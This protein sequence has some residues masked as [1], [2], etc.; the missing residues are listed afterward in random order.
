MV[1]SCFALIVGGGP[2]GLSLAIDLGRRNVPSILITE[3]FE[4]SPH[5]KC[6]YSN[7]RTVE[8]FRRL[9]IADLIRAAGVHGDFP[10]EVAFRTRFCGHEIARLSLDFLK[11][12]VWPGPEYPIQI[13][14]IA[15]EPALK[16]AAEAHDSVDV[17]FGWRLIEIDRTVVPHRATV[18][19]VASGELHHID[20]TYVIGC[21]G[22][23]SPTRRSIGAKLTGEDGTAQRSFVAGTMVA[24]FFESDELYERSGF[25]P[26]V[27]TWVINHEARGWI[28]SQNGVN[29]F[30]AHYVV[31][32]GRDWKDIS[33]DDILE[34]MLGAKV[35]YSVL[36]AG[37]WT[38]G[39]ALVADRYSADNC[40]IAG[41]AAHLYTPLGGFGMNT[42]VGDA[43][44]LGWKLTA[45]HE[46]WGGPD[47]LDSYDAERRPIG[48][49]NSQIGIHCAR[50]KD[51]WVLPENIEDDTA[52]AQEGRDTFGKFVV[53]DDRDEYATLGVQLGEVYRSSI[54]ADDPV[55]PLPDIWDRYEPQAI[56]GA[57]AP[58]FHLGDGKSAYDLLDEGFALFAF[59]G[60]DGSA[61]IEAAA[62]QAMPLKLASVGDR[63][64]PYT[65]NLALV[66]PDGHIAWAG[67]E[68]PADPGALIAMVRGAA[69]QASTARVESGAR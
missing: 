30:I 21:D 62:K 67:D 14:Q 20:A 51:G 46:G 2:V 60:A 64:E 23:R 13:A 18:E 41:D 32:E 5:A 54:V 56:A 63:P 57:R 19:D 10:R 38:G 27:M 35:D 24:V 48:R 34:Q 43:M 17:R 49:R 59:E 37:P 52:A 61:L 28:M 6:N 40:F 26:S 69:G 29:R 65:R 16:R 11:T 31:P 55:A 9:G 53:V 33:I 22:G 66:R 58:H 15:L 4:T 1:E 12:P 25:V 47:L 45:V 39:L 36:S 44:N 50:R 42:G 3:N 7:A 68:A 8:H